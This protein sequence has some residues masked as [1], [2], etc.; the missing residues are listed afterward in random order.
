M[1]ALLDWVESIRNDPDILKAVDEG[2]PGPIQFLETNLETLI[3]RMGVASDELDKL[4]ETEGKRP[5]YDTGST[6]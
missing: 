1:S 5:V 4:V 6:G 3:N 2:D